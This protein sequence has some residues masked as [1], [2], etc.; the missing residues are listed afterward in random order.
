MITADAFFAGARTVQASAPGRVNLLG[1]HTDYNDG[2]MLPIATPQRTA[3]TVACSS[4]AHFHFYSATLDE[5][6]DWSGGATPAAGFS[7][8]L[9]GCI[10][11]LRQRGIAVPP[12]RMYVTSN[13]SVGSGLSSSAALELSA[14]RALRGF[15]AFDL[16]DVV[17]AQIAQRAEIDYAGVNCGIMDQMAASLADEAHMLFLDARTLETRLLPLPQDSELIVIDTGVPRRLAATGYNT[18]RAE[19]EKA[20]SLLGVRALRDV[21]APADVEKL[22]EPYRRRA[23]HVVRE[24]LRVLRACAGVSAQEFG[25]LMNASHASLRDDYEVSIPAL[26]ELAAL[27]QAQP[28]VFGARLTGAGFGGACV[29]LCQRGMAASAGA[30]VLARF[31]AGGHDGRLLIPAPDAPDALVQHAG[32]ASAGVVP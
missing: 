6:V 21:A 4:D 2:F 32:T 12:L 8:Y 28:G 14:L 25:A 10:G 24:D 19:C 23:R 16:D 7:R 22:D 9:V 15:L 26:D 5:T 17:L 27:L 20:A 1:E 3:V 13:L 31:N 30:A 29:A 18:R 11:L